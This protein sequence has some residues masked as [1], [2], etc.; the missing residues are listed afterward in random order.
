M[1]AS[2]LIDALQGFGWTVGLD[3]GT[4]P[5]VTPILRRGR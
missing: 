1:R 5:A 4:A 2:S 3:T